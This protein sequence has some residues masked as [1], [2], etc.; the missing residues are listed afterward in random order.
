M[1]LS[2]TLA[3]W[4]WAPALRYRGGNRIMFPYRPAPSNPL[5]CSATLVLVRE[6][7]VRASLCM[8]FPLEFGLLSW[9]GIGH[10]GAALTVWE[11][12][13]IHL[14]LAHLACFRGSALPPP[15]DIFQ[16][17]WR[18]GWMAHFSTLRGMCRLWSLTAV[19]HSL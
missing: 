7:K 6:V 19:I 1:P 10:L 3:C 14:D 8:A 17:A 5:L 18:L 2:V 16:A 12:L 13:L 4:T 15:P 9:C 11:C